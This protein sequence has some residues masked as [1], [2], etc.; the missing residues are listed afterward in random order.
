[1]GTEH[2]GEKNW[3]IF[4]FF[5]ALIYVSKMIFHLTFDKDVFTEFYALFSFS[6]ALPAVAHLNWMLPT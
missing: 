3:I 4:P 5:T 1:M 6:S 2:L